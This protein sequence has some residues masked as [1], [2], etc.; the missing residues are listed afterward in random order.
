MRL[1]LIVKGSIKDFGMIYFTGLR[2]YYDELKEILDK[3][4]LK[5]EIIQEGF[6]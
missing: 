6:Y 3:A 4:G 2:E 1:N 5:F